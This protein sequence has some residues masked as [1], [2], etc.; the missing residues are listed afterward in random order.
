MT[1]VYKDQEGKKN[2]E[3]A[4][5]TK[6]KFA[7]GHYMKT[8]FY[9]GGGEPL[10]WEVYREYFFLMVGDEKK[11]GYWK[12]GFLNPSFHV[13]KTMHSIINYYK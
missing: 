4:L 8:V 13:G 11:S 7:L 9:S 3:V 10:V 12:E 2:N 1:S 6:M 5:T